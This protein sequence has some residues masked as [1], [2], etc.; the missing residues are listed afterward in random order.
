MNHKVLIADD[1]PNIL[2][3]LEFLMKR[4]GH[5]VL[6]ARDGEE[7]LALIRSERPALVL[8]DVMMPKKNGF[9][10]CQAVRA[11]DTLSGVQIVLLTAKGR[12]TD[13]AQGLGVGANAYVTKPFSTKDLA[14]KV[15]QML[16]G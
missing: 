12:D 2:I 5:Q 9:E 3:S 14:A 6:L 16:G 15:R 10:V 13:L 4:E 1:E 11:D 7:A 8:L